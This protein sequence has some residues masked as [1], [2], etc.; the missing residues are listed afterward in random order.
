MEGSAPGSKGSEMLQV[1]DSRLLWGTGLKA[2][3]RLEQVLQDEQTLTG[4]RADALANRSERAV[5]A[6]R[7]VTNEAVVGVLR[8]KVGF[9]ARIGRRVVLLVDLAKE[10]D[11]RDLDVV[12]LVAVR[13]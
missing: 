3:Q 13:A 12:E 1:K 2:M 5:E 4:D 10:H 9:A 11:H 7:G 6:H 8:G